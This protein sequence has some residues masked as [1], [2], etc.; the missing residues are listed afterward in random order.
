MGIFIPYESYPRFYSWEY[1]NYNCLSDVTMDR[2]IAFEYTI[3]SNPS[4]SFQVRQNLSKSV[5]IFPNRP[6]KV[7][8]EWRVAAYAS[9]FKSVFQYQ[10]KLIR[11]FSILF[12]FRRNIWNRTY[13]RTVFIRFNRN[14]DPNAYWLHYKTQITRSKRH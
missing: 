13:Y 12:D 7:R 2:L 4:K 1:M 9:L 5:Q 11:V 6:L 3:L 8:N 10:L 14:K